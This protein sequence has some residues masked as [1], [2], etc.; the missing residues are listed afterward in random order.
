MFSYGKWPYTNDVTGLLSGCL[1]LP[2][3]I[4]SP[5]P[6]PIPIPIP[7]LTKSSPS[8]LHNL[9]LNFSR[10]LKTSL[11]LLLSDFLHLLFLLSLRKKGRDF[12]FCP[13]P[14]ALFSLLFSPL[15]LSSSFHSTP[16]SQPPFPLSHFL[17]SF[18]LPCSLY[19][20]H[21]CPC[22]LFLLYFPS[23]VCPLPHP[24]MHL[25]PLS[26]PLIPP[27]LSLLPSLAPLCSLSL[28]LPIPSSS[29]PSLHPSLLPLHFSPHP[30]YVTPFSTPCPPVCPFVH[31]YPFPSSPS[32]PPIPKRPRSPP[33]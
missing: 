24:P 6:P 19:L 32:N 30:P 4:P 21:S 14:P 11:P 16:R 13:L 10:S 27:S 2:P 17:P 18:N 5:L 25:P 15:S 12:L 23:F 9:T 29:S 33:S 8:H 22:L 26:L 7:L 3:F 20:F 31:L 1:P 28:S